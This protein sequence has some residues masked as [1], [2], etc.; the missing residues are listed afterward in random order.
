LGYGLLS[1][2]TYRSGVSAIKLE[3]DRIEL[4][5]KP[6]STAEIDDAGNFAHALKV[7][8]CS[9]SQIGLRDVEFH[10]WK[11]VSGH[12]LVGRNLKKN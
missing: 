7:N 11:Y 1:Q 6:S 4:H 9:L 8:N 3:F 10:N 12:V 2:R 5:S